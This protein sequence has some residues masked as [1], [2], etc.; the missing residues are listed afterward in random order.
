MS[1]KRKVVSVHQYDMTKQKKRCRKWTIV[2]DYGERYANGR[3]KKSRSIFHG[4]YSE[5]LAHADKIAEAISGGAAKPK[6]WTFESYSKHWNESRYAAGAIRKATRDKNARLLGAMSRYIGS[7]DLADLRPH[8]FEEAYIG[9]RSGDTASGKELSGTTLSCIHT[10]CLSCMEHARKSGIIAVNPLADG[11]CARPK[12]DTKEKSALRLSDAVELSMMLDHG[13][14]YHV[15]IALMMECGLR[16]GEVCA[17]RW[18]DIRDGMVCVMHSMEE[19]GTLGPVKGGR[20]RIVPLSDYARS[21]LYEYR[22]HQ[23]T[24]LRV[25]YMLLDDEIHVMADEFGDPLRPH[26]LTRWWARHRASMGLPG[27]TLHQ[28]RHT[29]CTNLAEAGVH[30]KVMQKLMGHSTERVT[31]QVYSHVHDEQLSDAIAAMDA[32]KGR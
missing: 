1:E 8:M 10:V 13:N 4:T 29:F 5:A 6:S 12:P 18:G 30:P 28:F 27:W 23:E 22:M 19:D 3:P 26:S 15:A 7:V 32:I 20:S 2:A 25:R 17:L 24:V 11:L 21:I 31:M 16:R 14:R 9:M